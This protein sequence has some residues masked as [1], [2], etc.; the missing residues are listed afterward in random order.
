MSGALLAVMNS[1]KDC[2]A[3]AE[4]DDKVRVREPDINC[5]ERHVSLRRCRPCA[6]PAIRS[7]SPTAQPR[8][9][10]QTDHLIASPRRARIRWRQ[11]AATPACHCRALP[12][13]RSE[14]LQLSAGDSAA[15]VP[16][17]LE[18]RRRIGYDL[19]DVAF[20]AVVERQ[21][22]VAAFDP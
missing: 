5:R 18:R 6:L 17:E 10:Q 11:A 7:E 21:E 9:G 19:A 8:F 1:R 4:V 20:A 22:Q 15:R 12:A 13:H 14:L 2:L 3:I 16:P